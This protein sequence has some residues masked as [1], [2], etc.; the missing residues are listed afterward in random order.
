VGCRPFV[1]FL[2]ANLA[3]TM[4]S[5]RSFA[6]DD[7]TLPGD[8]AR[9]NVEIVLVSGD[10]AS[11]AA[12]MTTL[13]RSLETRG[14]DVTFNRRATLS[15]REVAAASMPVSVALTVWIDLGTPRAATVYVTEGKNVFARRIDLGQSL[16][17]VALDLLEVVVT[18]SVETVLSG[19]PLGVTR[20][21][22]ARSLERRPPP[23]EKV[24][25]AP[26]QP[27]STNEHSMDL[28]ASL[29]YEGSLIGP[30]T[31][32]DGP[33]LRIDGR[34]GR[35][36]FGLGFQ[37]HRPYEIT[38]RGANVRF[39]TQGC[40]L[41]VGRAF[42]IR[43]K[44]TLITALGAGADVTRVRSVSTPPD[45]TPTPAFFATDFVAR[46]FAGIQRRFDRLTLGATVGLD[47][48]VAGSSYVIKTASG[49][50]PVWT[51]WR[52]RP[53]LGLAIGLAL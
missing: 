31:P 47:V 44:L 40:L 51:P 2:W 41:S 7:G 1:I 30:T 21:E 43:P 35:L 25:A 22:F 10:A 18:S 19:R 5:G 27:P 6:N 23:T 29:L 38:A 50:R 20:E 48:N 8:A 52:F 39:T 4:I 34:R 26:A 32:I 33:G 14:T 11:D 13:R 45:V 24:P 16:D 42:S 37:G 17:S 12:L 28:S 9:P 53:V 3:G 49:T 36:W 15:A 46:P